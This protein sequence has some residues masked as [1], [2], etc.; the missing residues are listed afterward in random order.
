MLR[1]IEVLS[2][3]RVNDLSE[4]FRDA[5]DGRSQV[6]LTFRAIA[7]R[8]ILENNER[9]RKF[10]RC[11]WHRAGS[12]P[13]V[14]FFFST[15]QPPLDNYRAGTYTRIRHRVASSLGR[16]AFFTHGLRIVDRITE[17]TGGKQ[18]KKKNEKNW[19]TARRK[20][21]SRCLRSCA[22]IHPL[23]CCRPKTY[24]QL[25]SLPF[26]LIRLRCVAKVKY[27]VRRRIEGLFFQKRKKNSANERCITKTRKQKD[28]KVNKLHIM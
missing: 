13:D 9:R 18:K 7:C 16:A 27:L 19:N 12:F 4:S 17:P 26:P 28:D 20:I 1:S 21:Y 25:K 14:V 2:R 22:D 24:C 8:H 15:C 11:L 6:D 10:V 3:F 23:V 5:L